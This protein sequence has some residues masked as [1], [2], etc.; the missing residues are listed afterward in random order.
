MLYGSAYGSRAVALHACRAVTVR[1]PAGSN[2]SSQPCGAPSHD[3]HPN[4][5][6]RRT[7]NF[8]GHEMQYLHRRL[9]GKRAILLHAATDDAEVI[10]EEARKDGARDVREAATNWITTGLLF[11]FPA[12]GGLLF[13]YDIGATS[14]AL[15]SLKSAAT[16]GTNWYD[17]TSFQTGVVVSSSL[18]GAVAGSA[19]AFVFGERMGRR[20]ELCL[21]AALYGGAAVLT[22]GAGSLPLLVGVRAMYG[23]G[24]GFAMHAAP[25]YIAETAPPRQRGLLISLKEGF[26]VGGILLGYLAS[27]LL[28]DAVSGWRYIYALP[29]IPAGVLLAGMV[30]AP[31][32]PRWLLL[33]QNPG[34]AEAVLY[35][36]LG[37]NAAAVQADMADMQAS[38]AG[39]DKGPNT[40]MAVLSPQ[41]AKPLLVGLSLMLFQQIT[42]QPS[43]LYYASQI[44]ADAGFAAGQEAS[45][46]AVGLGFF[47]LVMTGIAVGTVD[48]WG[49]RPLL[50]G[51]VSGMVAALA[52]L[53]AAQLI[54][55]GAA[56]TWTSVIA[57]LLYVGCYQG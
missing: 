10:V 23:L 7:C 52:A 57:L 26:I 53:S 34:K 36:I 13:G 5:F 35:R 17:L 55:T 1:V 20:G 46:V 41:Y 40:G 29:I 19:A 2:R 42:G 31:E 14:G 8:G 43:V 18:L 38:I 30:W 25:A 54:L 45:G 51:G 49:R 32:S 33:T 27:Y 11:L 16:S 50:L 47:K 15:V 4:S 37:G 9:V 28:V 24:I 21:A 48:S 39:A 12:L 56:S 6:Q 44:F 3:P 22:L